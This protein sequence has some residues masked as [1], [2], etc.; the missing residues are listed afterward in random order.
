MSNGRGCHLFV[1]LCCS[2]SFLYPLLLFIYVSSITHSSYKISP[3]TNVGKSYLSPYKLAVFLHTYILYV[4]RSSLYVCA[5]II[6]IYVHRRTSQAPSLLQQQQSIL[7]QHKAHSNNKCKQ[8]TRRW[9]GGPTRSRNP[10]FIS[11][12]SYYYYMCP[13]DSLFSFFPI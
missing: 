5:F 4:Y 2:L 13:T 9:G 1:R 12:F 6:Y 7:M 3:G 8:I 11:C 10:F